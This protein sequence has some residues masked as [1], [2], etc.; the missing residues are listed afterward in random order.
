MDALRTVLTVSV[1]MVRPLGS[2]VRSMVEGSAAVRDV[3]A[4]FALR[5]DSE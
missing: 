1:M 2:V 3:E 5:I 4:N